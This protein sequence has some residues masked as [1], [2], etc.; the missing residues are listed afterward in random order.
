MF[1]PRQII[2]MAD[3]VDTYGAGSD[4]Y[5]PMGLSEATESEI[6]SLAMAAIASGYGFTFNADPADRDAAMDLAIDLDRAAAVTFS[7]GDAAT[8]ELFTAAWDALTSAYGIQES[9]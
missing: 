7:R 3:H 6:H 4:T 1:T 5:C 9:E 2:E 8:S